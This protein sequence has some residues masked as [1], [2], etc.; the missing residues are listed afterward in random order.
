MHFWMAT[1][2]IL[3][4]AI[5]MYWA[6]FKQSLMWKE[7][8][9]AGQLKYQFLETV[10]QLRGFYAMRAF[11][12]TLFLLGSVIGVYNLFRTAA[13]GSLLSNEQTEA[14][15]PEAAR[16]FIPGTPGPVTGLQ[17]ASAMAA[18]QAAGRSAA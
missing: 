9:E 1:L 3:F 10:T 12:G 11:G 5:P 13:N 8:T 7:F 16:S 6:G 14:P 18:I 2:G 15:A 4:Y 17:A